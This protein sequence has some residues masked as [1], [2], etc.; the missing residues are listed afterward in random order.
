MHRAHFL[1]FSTF[2]LFT[3]FAPF[4]AFA[5][6]STSTAVQPPDFTQL[7]ADAQEKIDSLTQDFLNN[8]SSTQELQQKSLAGDFSI[9]INPNYP[10]PNE[11]VTATA[12]A[13]LTDL[14]RALIVWSVNG[15]IVDRGIG[16]KTLSF[17]SG[18][19]GKKMTISADVTT[20]KGDRLYKDYSFTPLG[21]AVLWQAD[22]YTPPFYKGKAL[23]TAE[24]RLSAV[25][26]P[27]TSDARGALDAGNFVYEWT[28]NGATI[29]TASG[30][31]KNSFSFLAPQPFG[32][33]E[34]GVRVTSL[35][36][37][38]SSK[39]NVEVAVSSPV[40]AFYEDHPLLGVWYN[41]SFGNDLTLT[42]KEL[43]VVAEPYFFSNETSETPALAY[44]W[45]LNGKRVNNQDHTITLRSEEEGKG[46]SSLFLSM[47]NSKQTFQTGSQSL[48][49]HFNTE[50]TQPSF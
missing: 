26:L 15:K 3:F 10:N 35:N 19:S 30:Y 4:F 37:V 29:G 49:V 38:M 8:L 18:T 45:S 1:K 16:K 33:N 17:Q 9:R 28:K 41:R 27:E 22:T 47:R 24:S 13:Y 34:V 42:K 7:R 23:A 2:V 12:N 31:G 50:V 14:N 36:G 5:Q 21:V 44:F 32:K 40:I 46:D 20:E 43:S 48:L 39:K 25:A 6:T 11:A